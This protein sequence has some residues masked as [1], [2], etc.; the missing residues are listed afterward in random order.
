METREVI[1]DMDW[2]GCASCVFAIES[3]GRRLPGVREIRVF[4][5]AREI[6]IRYE[7]DRSPAAD[8]AAIVQRFGHT[9]TPRAES[10]A[11]PRG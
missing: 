1:L 10:E 4:P 2:A 7:G 9:A 3:A 11:P 5:A 6:R 8:V